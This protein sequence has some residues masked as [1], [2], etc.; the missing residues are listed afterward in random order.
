MVTP[1]MPRFLRHGDKTTIST[2]ISNLSD[3]VQS[4]NVII[5]FFNPSTEEVITN[6][7]VD[8]REQTF[9][10]EPG[11]SSDA[12][13]T[14]DVPDN[15]DI[16]GIRIIAQSGQF[17]DGEQHALPV[18]PNRMLVTESLRMDVKGNETKSF[19]ME[20]LAQDASDTR[21]DY[22]LT[23][24][25]TS[26]PA[27]YA[28][29]ALPVLGQPTSENAVSWFASYYANTLGAHIG[30]TYP[31]VS[32]MIEAWKKQ[33]GNEE[34][35]LSNLEKNEELKSVL[36]EETP[37][38]LEAE[39]ESEQKEK[40]SLLFD[41]NRSRNLTQTA[42][43]K[44]QDL[45]TNQGGWSW[46]KGFR[47]SVSITHY[48]LY[49]FSQLTG[50]QAVEY[51]E[52]TK[53]MQIKAIGFIDAE[54]VERY[55]MLKKYNKD[56]K[57]IK[58]IST[59]DLEYLFVRRNYS[60]IPMDSGVRELYRFYISV[61]E[62]NWTSYGL[63]E[64]S[65]IAQL[66][67]IEGKRGVMNSILES[68]REH[69]VVSEEMGMYWPNNRASVFMSLSAVSVHTFIMDAFKIGGA[70][71]DEMDNMKQ[72]LLKQKQ[73]QMW[74]TTHATMDAVYALLSGG[75]D[76]FTADATTSVTLGSIIVEPES[77]ELGTGYFKETWGRGEISKEMANITV[78]H[79][80]NTPAWGA[81]YL[82]YF[83]D[84]DKIGKTD[85]SLDIEKQLFVERTDAD[86]TKL[87]SV[88]E[89]NSLKVGDKVVV[90]LTVRTDRDMEFVNIK[91]VRAACFE[92]VNQL[93]AMRWQ[94]GVP[95]YQTAKDASTNFYFDNLPRG[96]YVFEY[97]VFVVRE[98]NYSNGISTIQS[99]YAPEFTSHTKGIR[100]IVN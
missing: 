87:F 73:T 42:L 50:L 53:S 28:V 93:S 34:T 82:Q 71:A 41:L 49:G 56:W 98:G 36:L 47:P 91:D 2:K 13:W 95:Y 45:Q 9:S 21:D 85:A 99:M 51:N 59:T 60:D 14:F 12:D 81:L 23:L 7:S 30:S 74:E 39:N 76:W 43:L 94:N 67:H 22:R 38:V 55:E 58:S 97:T 86:G 88:T 57:N 75:S 19:V 17:S 20:R 8:N 80:G 96:T 1:N 33:G 25:F 61:I 6:I 37:W 18:L 3:V 48:I 92:P 52:D 69:A 78:D 46:F 64:R 66:M 35:F 44:L 90:R 70:A 16:A 54:A 15:I 79:K 29:Q 11:A 100:I 84:M 24:E 83:E 72:W 10:L 89:E 31:K 62:K 68:Y 65:L 27:W 63:Y 4:G 32:A 77:S 40:L 26:N 5:E